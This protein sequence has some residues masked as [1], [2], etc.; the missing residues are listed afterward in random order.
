NHYTYAANDPVNLIDPTGLGAEDPLALL[1]RIARPIVDGASY[2]VTVPIPPDN[3]PI[4]GGGGGPLLGGEIMFEINEDGGGGPQNSKTPY[5]DRD[6]LDSC[7][8]DYF[9]VKLEEFRESRPGEFGYFKGTGPSYLPN[10]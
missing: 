4:R 7:T 8:Q 2:S 5:V 3:S 10:N 9:G 6:V 1:R